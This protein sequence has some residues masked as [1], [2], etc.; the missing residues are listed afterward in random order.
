MRGLRSRAGSCRARSAGTA[1]AYVGHVLEG[2]AQLLE[3]LTLVL[4]DEAHAPR[5]RLTP[6]AGDPGLDQHVEHG[7]LGQAQP[8]HDRDAQAREQ[9]LPVAAARPPRHL[10]AV[11]VLG[12]TSERDPDVAGVL[13]EGGD[14][15]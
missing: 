10:S 7:A 4:A 5:Q 12:L 1:A 11:A 3:P 13:A 8:G 15:R 2:L 9:L 6:A 14:A